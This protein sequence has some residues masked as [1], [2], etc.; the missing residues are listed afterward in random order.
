MFQPLIDVFL[1]IIRAAG[2][3]KINFESGQA[4]F[5]FLKE[6][7]RSIHKGSLSSG[8]VRETG[9]TTE[10]TGRK[11]SKSLGQTPLEAI[12]DLI[13]DDIT[14]KALYDTFI[15]DER[16]ARPVAAALRP[17]GVI[18]NYIRSRENSREEGDKMIDNVTFRLFNFNPEATRADGSVLGPE[19]FGEF[20]FANTRFAKLDARKQLFE[21]SQR[22][23]KSLDDDAA[24][25]QVADTVTEQSFETSKILNEKNKSID[26]GGVFI[27]DQN[28]YSD[29]VVKD[30]RQNIKDSGYRKLVDTKHYEDI[31]KDF[32]SH[33]KIGTGTTRNQVV[34]TGLLAKAFNAISQDVYGVDS[35]SI[36]ARGQNLSKSESEFARN[37]IAKDFEAIGVK[38]DIES[39]FPQFQFNS[40][41]GK[42]VGISKAIQDAFYDAGPGIRVP[43]LKGK[44]LNLTKIS[45]NEIKALFGINPDNTLMPYKSKMPWDGFV[46]GYVTQKSAITINQEARQSAGKPL[47]KVGI[48]KPKMLFSKSMKSL[49]NML[50]VKDNFYIEQKGKDGVL[51]SYGIDPTYKIK[52]SKDIDVFIEDVLINHIFKLGPKEMWFGPDGGTAFTSSSKNLGLSSKDPLWIEFVDEVKN[53]GKINSYTNTKG[54]K[55]KIVYGDPIPGVDSK[56]IWTLRNKYN[57]MFKNP[58]QI[59]NNKIE[60]N[61]FNKKVSAI[62]S[63][64]FYRINSSIRSNKNNAR[65]IA[66]YLGFVANDRAHWHK[67]GAQFVAFSKKLNPYRDK[68]GKLK[69]PRFELEH[70]MPATNAY[71]YLLDAALDDNVNFDATYKLIIDNYKLIA[72]DKAQDVKLTNARTE[73]GYSLQKRMPDNWSVVTG[74]FYER[75]FNSIVAAIQNGIDPAGIEMLDGTTMA[76]TYL[77]KSDGSPINIKASKSKIKVSNDNREAVLNT[78]KYAKSGVSRGMS[79]FDFDDTLAQT[80]SGVRATVPNLDDQPKPSRKVIFLAGGAG[81]G[82]GNVV[83]KLG[84]SDMGFKIVNSDISL[85][86]L[87]KNSGLPA[88]MN[89]LTPAQRSTLGKLGAQARKIA[90]GKMMKYQGNANGVVVDGTGG[91]VKSMQKLVD[92]FKS[93]GYDVSMIFVDTSLDVALARNRARQERSLLDSIVRRNH[94]AV[95]ANKSEFKN[96]FGKRFMEVNTDNLTQASPMPDSLVS[97]VSDFV[98]SYEKL[99]LDAEEFATQGDDILN[100]GGTFDFSEFN[101]VVDGTPGPF[102]EK[103]RQRIKKFGNKDVFVLTARPQASAKSIQ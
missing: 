16:R 68:E 99:R 41:T 81:S 23:T 60:N 26:T 63:A 18:N 8:I 85:E 24:P 45:D 21:E 67:L 64:L 33:D 34:P 39:T 102:L 22:R 42:S 91:S 15:S 10:T 66:T 54:K 62:H 55:I 40:L 53:L 61:D 51:K 70:A 50:N 47:A 103:A 89:D 79:T 75:Y 36:I 7:N 49:E 46:K 6:Y 83:S 14:T 13:P 77:I 71:L 95:Q 12:N 25:V 78:F 17:G 29:Q 74:N 82:K 73:S 37:K 80:K 5:D 52:S 20:L 4:M 87:K 86:W 57:S 30:V 48:S 93:K 31:K 56:D 72:L 3:K 90:R 11:M 2:F 1:P 97:K 88:D 43:N 58:N 92:E 94:E 101:K 27:K 76:Q 84:L 96:M 38:K 28:K 65:A 100:R 32:M 59:R 35:R 9:G 19:G 98:Y 44:A 69:S